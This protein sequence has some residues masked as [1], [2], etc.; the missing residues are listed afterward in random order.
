MPQ[1]IVTSTPQQVILTAGTDTIQNLDAANPVYFLL[2]D[3]AVTATVGLHGGFRLD[4]NGIP[5]DFPP[6]QSG[7]GPLW[8]VC[9]NGQTAIL[10][11]G[12]F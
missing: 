8:V 9:A 11:Y 12:S 5:W 4:P 1:V 6:T 10:A 3:P 2:N 7:S